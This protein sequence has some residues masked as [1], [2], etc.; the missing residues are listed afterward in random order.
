MERLQPLVFPPLLPLACAPFAE[1]VYSHDQ[2]RA[3]PSAQNVVPTKAWKT[4]CLSTA[5]R[6][7]WLGAVHVRHLARLLDVPIIIILA[8][9]SGNYCQMRYPDP[10]LSSHTAPTISRN[11]LTLEQ[12]VV[13]QFAGVSLKA[14]TLDS[15]CVSCQQ[16]TVSGKGVQITLTASGASDASPR[17]ICSRGVSGMTQN[18]M[19]LTETAVPRRISQA[20]QTWHNAWMTLCPCHYHVQH[21]KCP[22]KIA[23]MVLG[24]MDA[25]HP[26]QAMSRKTHDLS[27]QSAHKNACQALRNCGQETAAYGSAQIAAP[28]SPATRAPNRPPSPQ[29]AF[30][31]QEARARQTTSVEGP[32]APEVDYPCS[33]SHLLS[34]ASHLSR[35]YITQTSLIHTSLTHTSLALISLSQTYLSHTYSHAHIS[36]ANISLSRT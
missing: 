35:T 5:L 12:R 26:P 4:I 9:K 7:Y 6:G 29:A 15:R 32:Q 22:A 30:G 28:S 16:I 1:R 21:V 18:V 27:I 19:I 17:M 33:L 10:Y 25:F 36:L 11:V 23:W 2:L 31:S 13:P 20:K 3:N 34:L 8:V 24:V 14:V